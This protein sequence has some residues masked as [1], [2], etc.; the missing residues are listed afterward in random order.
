M[1]EQLPATVPENTNSISVAWSRINRVAVH[2]TNSSRILASLDNFGVRVSDDGG[3]S[4]V[5]PD[6]LPVSS[7]AYDLEFSADGNIV[8]TAVGD[9]IYKSSDSGSSFSKLSGGNVNINGVG[10]KE[11]AISPTNSDYVYVSYSNLTGYFTKIVRTT[12]GGNSWQTIGVYDEEFLNP[13]SSSGNPQGWYDHAL[14]V[15]PIDENR[16]LLGGIQLWSWSTSNGWAK[17][18]NLGDFGFNL[19]YIHADKHDFAFDPNNPG[20]LFIATDGGVFRSRNAS[21]TTP[22]YIPR[23]KNYNVTQ[24][25]AVGADNEGRVLAGAQDNGT[26]YIDYVGTSSQSADIVNGGDGGFSEISHINPN[27]LF[28]SV[29]NGVFQRSSNRGESFASY[30]QTSGA[31][32][33]I[34]PQNF[35]DTLFITPYLLWEDVRKYNRDIIQYQQALN[36][37][38]KYLEEQM[39]YDEY[40]EDSIAYANDPVGYE[41]T[42]VSP[43]AEVV[44]EPPLVKPNGTIY[45]GGKKIIAAFDALNVSGISDCFVLGDMGGTPSNPNLLTA[46]STTT[47]GKTLWAGSNRGTL[48]RITG[49]EV[50]AEDAENNG[51]NYDLLGFPTKFVSEDPSQTNPDPLGSVWS[52]FIPN[53]PFSGEYITSVKVH[54]RNSNF[55]VVTVGGFGKANNIYLSKNAKSGTPT[56]EPIKGSGLSALPDMPVYDAIFNDPNGSNPTL[57]FAATELGVWSYNINGGR[58]FEENDGLGGRVKTL[59]IRQESLGTTNCPVIY[60]A[61]HG[62]GIFRAV[63]LTPESCDTSLPIYALDVEETIE[64]VEQKSLTIYPNPVKNSATINFN[65][66]QLAN[67]NFRIIA[68]NGQIMQEKYIGQSKFTNW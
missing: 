62:R 64:L 25:Y 5:S 54:P 61:T 12:D 45:T 19:F 68:M 18:D 60:I 63:N 8:Y 21:N 7:T 41:P 52:R 23:N 22:T 46:V 37:Y 1:F 65:L 59:Q 48:R 2:P 67:V 16:V 36:A 57:I 24:F 9:A 44:P 10:R 3:S 42:P 38:N 66:N 15:D 53:L 4:W 34:G 56:F 58:W 35:P 6:G 33:C 14:I 29:Q 55:V 50:N 49:L 39:A 32:E 30:L 43:P 11:I 17:L 31:T 26:S 51:W 28:A 13:F 27:T 20:Q 40:V 47:D